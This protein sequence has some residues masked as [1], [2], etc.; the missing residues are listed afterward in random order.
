M[1]AL[2]MLLDAGADVNATSTI[3]RKTFRPLELFLQPSV[4]LYYAPLMPRGGRDSAVLRCM[5]LERAG[6]LVLCACW[7]LLSRGAELGAG[8]RTSVEWNLFRMDW[9][10]LQDDVL[11]QRF[12]HLAIFLGLFPPC[13][14]IR[15][16]TCSC[17]DHHDESSTAGDA[18]CQRDPCVSRP[19]FTG[20][21][22]PEVATPPPQLSPATNIIPQLST[23]DLSLMTV[24]EQDGTNIDPA[25]ESYSHPPT[26]STAAGSF[27]GESSHHLHN[28]AG[29][30]SLPGVKS[31]N[32]FRLEQNVPTD[33]GTSTN[34][35]ENASRGPRSV[36]MATAVPLHL[37]GC[38]ARDVPAR[39]RY[40]TQLWLWAV[41]ERQHRILERCVIDIVR[42]SVSPRTLMLLLRFL[43]FPDLR[44]MATLTD[45]K[46]R[47]WHAETAS[48]DRLREAVWQA[49]TRSLKHSAKVVILIATRWRYHSLQRLPL[50]E[51]LKR[52]LTDAIC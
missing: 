48:G 29:L 8:F 34:G 27:Y 52:Y 49:H 37:P 44:V 46:F 20:N 32:G 25:P 23:V 3:F 38:P 12:L 15:L 22:L 24:T 9:M 11:K 4:D 43:A 35:M 33:V 17:R 21:P 16:L 6:E 39:W 45:T 42:L 7:E 18:S 28:E 47:E 36:N 40:Q 14:Q 31:S 2:R 26:Y 41:E 1:D 51:S 5:D 10:F 13:C 50:P 30:E 19:F